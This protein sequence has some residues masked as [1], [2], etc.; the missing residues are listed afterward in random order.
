MLLYTISN[1]KYVCPVNI[2]SIKVLFFEKADRRVNGY[3]STS[4]MLN[5]DAV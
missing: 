2:A 4:I 5:N 3:T 1:H